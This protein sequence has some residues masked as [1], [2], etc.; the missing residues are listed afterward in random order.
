MDEHARRALNA[1][2]A[3]YRRLGNLQAAPRD[4]AELRELRELRELARTANLAVQGMQRCASD[5][6]VRADVR[7]GILREAVRDELIDREANAARLLDRQRALSEAQ[8]DNQSILE[9]ATASARSI[10]SAIGALCP[11]RLS[12]SATAGVAVFA[13]ER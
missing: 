7:H 6:A 10:E 1:T 3:L 5:E 4:V 9:R 8:R 2:K 12:V 13:E 11:H